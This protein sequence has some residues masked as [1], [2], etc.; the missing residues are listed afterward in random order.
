MVRNLP[1]VKK[2]VTPGRRLDYEKSHSLNW[3]WR[4]GALILAIAFVPVG[5]SLINFGLNIDPKTSSYGGSPWITAGALTVA[6]GVVL[7]VANQIVRGRATT[8]E[9]IDR[10]KNLTRF[11]DELSDL[12]DSVMILN[13]SSK[14]RSDATDFFKSMLKSARHL[15]PLDGARLCVYKFDRRD[16]EE[17]EAESD[18]FL[19]LAASSGRGDLPR[20]DFVPNDEHGQA[21]IDI[22]N[23]TR[24]YPVTN[25]DV[26]ELAIDWSEDTIWKSFL[27]VPIRGQGSRAHGVLL[28]DTRDETEWT[29]EHVSI[30]W[31]ISRFLSIGM[32]LMHANVQTLRFKRPQITIRDTQ[33]G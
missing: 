33:S 16:T 24:A 14:G 26:S 18:K 7:N 23:G 12:I 28:I 17:P 21:L 19:K 22:A 29:L 32:D 5:I 10:K 2:K 27:A 15:T 25:P 31:T 6:L 13:Q 9:A 30:G 3:F 1:I 8:R 4:W 11:N 20:E